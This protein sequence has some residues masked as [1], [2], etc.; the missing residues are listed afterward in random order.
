M[1]MTFFKATLQYVILKVTTSTQTAWI[2]PY[3]N[4]LVRDAPMAE[5]RAYTDN[6]S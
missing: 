6:K 3:V 2:T 4:R 1:M 5:I